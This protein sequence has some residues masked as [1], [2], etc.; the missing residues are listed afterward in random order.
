VSFT[1]EAERKTAYI[2]SL[3]GGALVD[4]ASRKTPEQLDNLKANWLEDPCWDIEATEGFEL[5]QTE[6]YIF[7]LQTEL[8]DAR[9]ELTQFREFRKHMRRFLELQS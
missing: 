1:E 7:R 2:A 3:Q 9:A 5:H 4:E 8:Q 6:L